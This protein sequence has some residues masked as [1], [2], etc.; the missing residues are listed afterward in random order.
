MCFSDLK[1]LDD[2][3]DSGELLPA[4]ESPMFLTL[5]KTVINFPSAVT[6]TASTTF[7]LKVSFRIK[8]IIHVKLNKKFDHCTSKIQ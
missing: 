5:P 3:K 6:P 7:S 4:V 2:A 8:T 1:T